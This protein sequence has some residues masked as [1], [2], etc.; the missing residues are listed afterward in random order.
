MSLISY[1][2]EKSLREFLRRPNYWAKSN[3][4]AYPIKINRAILELYEWVD[5]P[6]DDDCNCKKYGCEKH[7][8]RKPNVS[9][10]DCYEHFLNCYVDARNHK[11]VLDGRKNIRGKNAIIATK[12][13]RNN[14]DSISGVS[15]KNHLLCSD[16]CHPLHEAM[17]K[18][19]RPGPDSIYQAK[20]LSI[21]CFDTFT[22]YDNA[23][24]ALFRR[25][26]NKPPSYYEMMK[27]IRQDI[28][29][30]LD[31]SGRSLQDFRNYDNPSEFF[32][33]IP[34][35]NPKPIG[36]IIDKIYLTL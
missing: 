29:N 34:S 25:D 28:M 6:C 23:S 18:K 31:N 26:F 33:D 10:D 9:F 7:L 3:R 5:C 27:C 32:P 12:A 8:T 4:N 19:F 2:P 35:D 14:W 22:A 15:S 24:V 16:W 1:F 17:A 20:W 13:I 11:A 36:N 21:L 30:H